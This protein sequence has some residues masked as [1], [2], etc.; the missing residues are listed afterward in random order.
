MWKNNRRRYSEKFATWDIIRKYNKDYKLIF[1]GDATMSPYEILQPG[2]SVEYNNE[3]AGAEWLQRLTNA[4]PKFAWIN[5]EPQGV[6]GYR[7]SISRD[8]AADEPAHVPAHPARAR[9]SHATAG[10][11][12]ARAA[13][14]RMLSMLMAGVPARGAAPACRSSA[15]TPTPTSR[16]AGRARRSPLYELEVRAPGTLQQLLLDYLDLARFQSA[17]ASEAIT[18][19]ELERLAARRAGAGARAARDRGLLRRRPSR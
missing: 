16:R 1:V 12:K 11:M 18:P 15:R 10:E 5:P 14:A 13:S 8:P 19:A 17:P 2:G 6:W 7:Q 3:E 9:R 4:F